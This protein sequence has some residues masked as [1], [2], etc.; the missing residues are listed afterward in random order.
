MTEPAR[1]AAGP[2]RSSSRRGRTKV[3]TATCQ[4]WKSTSPVSPKTSTTQQDSVGAAYT[5][6]R[7]GDGP[8]C[9]PWPRRTPS[10]WSKRRSGPKA[11]NVSGPVPKRVGSK[12]RIRA[13][14]AGKTTKRGSGS[15]KGG[16]GA[17]R[18]KTEPQTVPTA[19]AASR[20]RSVS[21]AWSVSRGV[22]PSNVGLGR[23]SHRALAKGETR[24]A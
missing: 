17:M 24:S 22:R 5:M 20:T 9:R 6:R 16:G 12:M 18:T 7:S 19:A 2:R 8:A 21:P 3:S 4:S 15:R 10:W 13:A 23:V 1:I 14:P 11:R